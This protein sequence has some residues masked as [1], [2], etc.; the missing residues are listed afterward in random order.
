MIEDADNINIMI[1][2]RNEI[3]NLIERS[4][5][6]IKIIKQYSQEIDVISPSQFLNEETRKVI[7][8]FPKRYK[9]PMALHEMLLSPMSDGVFEYQV[10]ED[11]KTW[12]KIVP[13][14]GE[15]KKIGQVLSAFGLGDV[16][17][18]TNY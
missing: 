5:T 6:T 18:E 8:D 17:D 12:V 9:F 1:E 2:Y 13:L 3:D 16:I 14:R 15:N 11:N 10:D 4:N 7:K